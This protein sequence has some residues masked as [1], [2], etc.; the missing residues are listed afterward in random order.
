MTLAYIRAL[1]PTYRVMYEHK[2]SRWT[3]HGHTTLLVQLL[4]LSGDKLGAHFRSRQALE[5]STHT[6]FVRPWEPSGALDTH[7]GVIYRL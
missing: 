6:F 2:R 7:T 5:A 3:Q 4:L 1:A